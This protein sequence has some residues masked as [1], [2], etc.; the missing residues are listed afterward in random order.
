MQLV[1]LLTRIAIHRFLSFSVHSFTDMMYLDLVNFVH[2][3][4]SLGPFIEHY[5]RQCIDGHAVQKCI[6][7]VVLDGPKK[8]LHLDV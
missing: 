3:F 1:G 8:N 4:P 7:C 5:T 2:Y 6:L